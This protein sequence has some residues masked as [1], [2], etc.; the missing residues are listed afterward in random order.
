M[1]IEWRHRHPV[2]MLELSFHNILWYSDA[3]VRAVEKLLV[4]GILIT[5]LFWS[6][7]LRYNKIWW[8]RM[9]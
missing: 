8:K 3:D 4:I 2:Y 1:D 7:L 9:A 5:L 6:P